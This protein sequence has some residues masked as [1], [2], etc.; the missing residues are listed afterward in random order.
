MSKDIS[1]LFTIVKMC[2]IFGMDY[3]KS[4]FNS[5]M[6]Y[7]LDKY[8][9]CIQLVGEWSKKIYTSNNTTKLL[10]DN[11]SYFC[12]ATYSLLMNKNFEPMAD[13][14]ICTSIL[15]YSYFNKPEYRLI[16]DADTFKYKFT[17]T[18]DY[19]DDSTLTPYEAFNNWHQIASGYLPSDS[20]I[21]ECLLTMKTDNK[22][23]YRVFNNKK[24][25]LSL[26]NCENPE[27]SKVKFIGI[28]IMLPKYSKPVFVE[29]PKN[30]YLVGNEILS[31]SF[32]KRI[33]EHKSRTLLF[34]MDYTV[35][36]LDNNINVC[37]LHCNEYIVLNK[38][39]YDIIKVSV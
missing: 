17:E 1:I 12:Y 7:T 32:I 11:L 4:L 19:L 10:Y 22:Y 27:L 14:W 23:I 6:I 16:F 37:V 30:A 13:E 5:F 38:H 39:S 24:K 34:D 18:Y 15:Y 26:K 20:D 35:R 33:L 9:Q 8:S 25:N 36:V 3:V 28:E 29:I 31:C 2:W 21:K